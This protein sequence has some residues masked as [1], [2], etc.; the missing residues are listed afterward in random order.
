MNTTKLVR[1]RRREMLN[2]IREHYRV[3]KLDDIFR[4]PT[5]GW[6]YAMRSSQN[7]RMKEIAK[8]IGFKN[9]SAILQAEDREI[10][11]TISLKTMERIAEALGGKFV[12]AIVPHQNLKHHYNNAFHRWLRMK[13]EE[14]NTQLASHHY[15]L[16][17]HRRDH[18]GSNAAQAPQWSQQ[19]MDDGAQG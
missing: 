14:L 15:P 18:S 12:Y 10:K 11:K 16:E 17:S 6:I 1:R 13:E 4:T 9:P 7:I 3:R 19:V 5:M 8:K 2:Q